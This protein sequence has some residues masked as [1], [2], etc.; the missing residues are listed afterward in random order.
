VLPAVDESRGLEKRGFAPYLGSVSKHISLRVEGM[1]CGGCVAA[2]RNV[3]SRQPGVSSPQV[4]IGKVELDLDEAVGSVE[5]IR[6][7]VKKAGYTVVT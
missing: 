3:V 1:T 6:E 7:A 4:E 2:V 5:N